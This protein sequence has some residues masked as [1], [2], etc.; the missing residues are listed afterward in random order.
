MSKSISRCSSTF[1]SQTR[2]LLPSYFMVLLQ[3]LSISSLIKPIMTMKMEII[4]HRAAAGSSSI[5][6]LAP[7]RPIQRSAGACSFLSVS[8]K[9]S[10]IWANISST[11]YL[12]LT[13]L[14]LQPQMRSFSART[15]FSFSIRATRSYSKILD[16]SSSIGT[17]SKSSKCC[18]MGRRGHTQHRL[19]WGKYLGLYMRESGSRRSGKSWPKSLRLNHSLWGRPKACQRMQILWTSSGVSYSMR[20]R[21]TPSVSIAH[22]RD[23]RVR[24]FLTSHN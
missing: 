15:R 24:I 13:V 4:T 22:F 9:C 2:T 5:K 18:S 10:W 3:M 23:S 20:I 6:R 19:H 8:G 16:R 12:Q 14:M 1:S 21:T 7:K 17:S 11:T